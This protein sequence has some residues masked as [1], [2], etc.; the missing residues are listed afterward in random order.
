MMKCHCLI[1]MIRIL[2]NYYYDEKSVIGQGQWSKVY[3]GQSFDKEYVAI[4]VVNRINLSRSSLKL[5]DNEIRV[6]PLLDCPFMVKLIDVYST[7]DKTYIIM[8]YC[9]DG[10]LE[11]KNDPLTRIRV[12][13]EE[14][15]AERVA[16]QEVCSPVDRGPIQAEEIK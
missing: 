1:N 4:K 9:E 3:K 16:V 7:K 5:L 8:E 12:P 14:Q 13:A 11:R 10:T 2:D 6:L 15:I